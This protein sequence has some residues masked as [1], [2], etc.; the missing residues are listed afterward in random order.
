[1]TWLLE[2]PQLY[3]TDIALTSFDNHSFFGTV[4]SLLLNM[5]SRF[6]ITFLPMGQVSFNF[7]AAVTIC[8]DFGAPQNKGCHCFHCCPIY[9]SW[10]DGTRCHDLSFLNV[11]FQANFFSLLFHF[12]QELFSSSS[13][14]AIR[15]VSSAFLRLFMFLPAVLIAVEHSDGE[16]AP[17]C[18]CLYLEFP[19]PLPRKILFLKKKFSWFCS[20]WRKIKATGKTPHFFL[21]I[22]LEFLNRY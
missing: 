5:L 11:E 21:T 12:H 4:M 17:S 10:S 1:M 18:S 16:R 19:C 13:L 9:L 8:S 7:M 15:V 2:K 3:K 22:I 6:V 20:L 14:S